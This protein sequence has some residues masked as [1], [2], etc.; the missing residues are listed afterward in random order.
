MDRI[1]LSILARTVASV[2]FPLTR[3]ASGLGGMLSVCVSMLT[4][5]LSS[6][7]FF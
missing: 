3:N 5:A 4:F 2:T 7:F 6:A 1:L